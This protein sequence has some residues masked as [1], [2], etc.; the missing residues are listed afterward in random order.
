MRDSARICALTLLG[1]NIQHGDRKPEQQR[2]ECRGALDPRAGELK[3]RGNKGAVFFE[4]ADATACSEP[5]IALRIS[6]PRL[7]VQVV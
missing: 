3:D 5:V 2:L 1:V 7:A 6:V 4:R